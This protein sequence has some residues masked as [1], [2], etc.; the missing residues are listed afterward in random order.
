M[1]FSALAI[2]DRLRHESIEVTMMYAHL[3]PN[4]QDEMADQLDAERGPLGA[5]STNGIKPMKEVRE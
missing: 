1:G 3:F 4:K 5:F 2:A